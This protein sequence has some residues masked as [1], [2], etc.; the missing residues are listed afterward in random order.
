MIRN[1]VMEICSEEIQIVWGKRQESLLDRTGS[2]I[3]R[4][5]VTRAAGIGAEE[6]DSLGEGEHRILR[7]WRMTDF[8]K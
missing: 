3:G 2:S 8:L 1:T 5:V 7:G 4:K 6:R